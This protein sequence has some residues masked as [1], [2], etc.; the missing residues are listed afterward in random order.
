MLLSLGIV[1]VIIIGVWLQG[2]DPVD[3]VI[4]DEAE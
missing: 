4:E 3:T 1:A 2:P